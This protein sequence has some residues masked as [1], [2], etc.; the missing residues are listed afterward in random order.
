MSGLRSAL[1]VIPEG[2]SVDLLKSLTDHKTEGSV[3]VSFAVDV[4]SNECLRSS[5]CEVLQLLVPSIGNISAQYKVSWQ[6]A[7]CRESSW[8]CG[9]V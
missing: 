3:L 5:V 4:V 6:S 9:S 1:N 2:N 8:H 7:K